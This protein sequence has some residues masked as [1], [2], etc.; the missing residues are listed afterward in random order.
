MGLR[1][2]LRGMA[3]VP[4]CGH[5]NTGALSTAEGHSLRSSRGGPTLTVAFLQTVS[6]RWLKAAGVQQGQNQGWTLPAALW[7]GLQRWRLLIAAQES[8]GVGSWRA[9]RAGGAPWGLETVW[10]EH[11]ALLLG[12]IHLLLVPFMLGGGLHAPQPTHMPS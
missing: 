3:F 12:D 11:P 8:R 2:P 5:K 9:A 7:R 6:S 4:Y 1:G 10:P